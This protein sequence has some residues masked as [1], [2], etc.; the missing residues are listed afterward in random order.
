MTRVIRWLLPT[1]LALLVGRGWFAFGTLSQTLLSGV[2]VALAGWFVAPLLM[3]LYLLISLNRFGRHRGI[4][5][6][7]CY[8][9]GARAAFPDQLP[10]LRRAL[11][12]VV[13]DHDSGAPAGEFQCDGP[14]HPAA[15]SGDDGGLLGAHALF[16]SAVSS[17][18]LP[19]P[20][21]NGVASHP[22]ITSGACHDSASRPRA[23]SLMR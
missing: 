6:V 18:S 10:G 13:D 7:A 2:G 11:P 9:H 22:E 1:V 8:R 23:S 20:G 21:P 4:G 5:H 19:G 15:R 3:G 14:A 12:V 16:S 17:R